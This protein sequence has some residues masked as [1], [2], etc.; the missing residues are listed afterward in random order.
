MPTGNQATCET[1]KTYYGD[2]SN[3]YFNTWCVFFTAV[4][5]F[6]VL[7]YIDSAGGFLLVAS[8]CTRHP[9]ISRLWLP[10]S[11]RLRAQL[12][13]GPEQPLKA[14]SSV[15][16]VPSLAG[17]TLFRETLRPLGGGALDLPP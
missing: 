12:R 11:H 4:S 5:A 1:V 14:R 8:L 17:S 3:L 6:H 9:R 13:A 15:C 10:L 16:T 2:E 7:M